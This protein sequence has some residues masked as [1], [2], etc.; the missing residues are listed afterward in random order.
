M[1][2][3]LSS[4]SA[5]LALNWLDMFICIYSI[6]SMKCHFCSNTHTVDIVVDIS[7]LLVVLATGRRVPGAQRFL[8]DMSP[9]CQPQ[10][11]AREEKEDHGEDTQAG[12]GNYCIQ[13]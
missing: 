9:G 10:Q 8:V 1:Q 4:D 12:D 3:L 5:L 13:G 7:I 2:P 11:E 6:E